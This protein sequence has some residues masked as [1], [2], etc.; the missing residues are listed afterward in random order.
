ME[1][2][3]SKQ[4]LRKKKF[5][6]LK[7]K[8]VNG[9]CVES[10]VKLTGYKNIWTEHLTKKTDRELIY[11]TS[12]CLCGKEEDLKKYLKNLNFSDRNITLVIDNSYKMS[13]YKSLENQKIYNFNGDRALL[14]NTCPFSE[15][16]NN[17]LKEVIK[18]KE[19][20]NKNLTLNDLDDLLSQLKIKDTG[21][22]GN[23]SIS[24]RLDGIGNDDILKINNCKDNGNGCKKTKYN[25]N[26]IRL[27]KIGTELYKVGYI[28]NEKYQEGIRNFLTFY[29]S[30]SKQEIDNYLNDDVEDED[31][32]EELDD[33][34]EDLEDE[35]LE[36]EELDEDD[37]EEDE[38]LYDDDVDGEVMDGD[39]TYGDDTDY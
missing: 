21:K 32:D 11:V 14:S 2:F 4:I 28:E 3:F 34:D 20:S 8:Y 31:E 26:F 33:I 37:M 30:F 23:K 7:I 35:D 18:F 29:Y 6:Y 27:G 24:T 5:K 39:E 9:K 15:N 16:F 19:N 25:N 38:D 17:E 22:K 36:G 13:N 12:L 1:E 10:E